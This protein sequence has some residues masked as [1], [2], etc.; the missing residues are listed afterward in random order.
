MPSFVLE[1]VNYGAPAKCQHSIFY[2]RNPRIPICHN[3]QIGIKKD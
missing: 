3:R 1:L 2:S